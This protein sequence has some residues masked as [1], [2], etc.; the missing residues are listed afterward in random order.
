MPDNPSTRKSILILGCG[1]V[2][3]ALYAKLAS[4][5]AASVSSRR[6]KIGGEGSPESPVLF[7]LSRRETWQLVENY[8]QIVWTFPA[9]RSFSDVALALEFYEAMELQQKQV[10][11]LGST[12]SFLNSLPGEL[13][14]ETFSLDMSQPR[15]VAEEE[16]R[17]RSAFI[18]CLAGIYGPGRDPCRWLLNGLIKNSLSFINLI[19]ISDIVNILDCWVQSEGFHGQRIIASDGR[20][21]R[22][23]DV[24]EQLKQVGFLSRNF[25]AESLESSEGSLSKRLNNS[26]LIAEL[27]SG[28]FHLYPEQGL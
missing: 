22:W 16:L 5:G 26:R 19:H 14:D 27:Y 18:L 2:G 25:Q 28:G 24:I 4:T 7:D 12:S 6:G 10:V 1:Y 13:V 15:V 23:N 11:V 3:S 9:A 20:H 8:Q 17:K 21:R